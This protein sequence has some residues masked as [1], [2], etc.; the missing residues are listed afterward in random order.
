MKL[1]NILILSKIIVII[2]RIK[3]LYIIIKN[4]FAE[5]SQKST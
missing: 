2:F 3:N 5:Q 1:G 4:M